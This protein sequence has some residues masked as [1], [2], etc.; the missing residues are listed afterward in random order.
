[1]VCAFGPSSSLLQLMVILGD[2]GE[3]EGVRECYEVYGGGKRL[4]ALRVEPKHHKRERECDKCDK[5]CS[6]CCY[7][8][9]SAE[10][11]RSMEAQSRRLQRVPKAD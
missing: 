7:A 8:A 11:G 3:S 4:K 6:S 9:T 1:M 2:P 10:M 5:R